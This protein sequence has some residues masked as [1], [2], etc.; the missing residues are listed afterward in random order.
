MTKRNSISIF[1]AI[2]TVL[3]GSTV[4]AS[5]ITEDLADCVEGVAV[6]Q[7]LKAKMSLK[8]AEFAAYHSDCIP[9]VSAVDPVLVGMTG[10]ILVLQSLSPAKLARDA[11]VCTDQIF[12]VAQRPIA[13]MIDTAMNQSGLSSILPSTS[14]TL[15]R[16]IANGASNEALYSIPGMTV[17]TSKLTCGCAVAE[18]GVPVEALKETVENGLKTINSCTGVVTK[19]I[20]GAYAAAYAGV[21]AVL[22]AATKIYNTAQNALNS[23]GCGWLWSC[24]SA[25]SGPPFFC[26]GYGLVRAQGSSVDN[27]RAQYDNLWKMVNGESQTSIFNSSNLSWTG[28]NTPKKEPPPSPY[29]AMIDTCETQYVNDV[30]RINKDLALTEAAAKAQAEGSNYALA[31][32]AR[33]WPECQNDPV[34]LNGIGGVSNLFY[35]DIQDPDIRAYFGKNSADPFH[36]TVKG[37]NEKYRPNAQIIVGAGRD[38]RYAVLRANA[39]AAPTD[40]LIAFGCNPFLGRARQSLCTSALG[41]NTCKQYVNAGA[42]NFCVSSTA[43]GAYFSAGRHL[44]DFVQSAGCV[45]LM[46]SAQRTNQQN[47]APMRPIT[48]VQASR[49]PALVR[50]ERTVSLTE[51]QNFQCLSPSA[52]RNCK[53]FQSGGSLVDCGPSRS[54]TLA[55]TRPIT[56]NTIASLEKLGGVQG[57]RGLGQIPPATSMVPALP[58]LRSRVPRLQPA[59]VTEAPPTTTTQALPPLILAPSRQLP[60]L[61][62]RPG[63]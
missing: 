30:D 63:S 2:L 44:R 55:A 39:A 11:D 24:P 23:L 54:L 7:L 53:S 26:T 49:S 20:G 35:G 22:D 33:W 13:G 52:W 19:L 12:S 50:L 56:L 57:V 6:D 4:S 31:Y 14:R 41:M 51:T 27:I 60:A 29:N 1:L 58:G 16:N 21:E 48:G 37:L 32:A 40:R 25:P 36:A 9:L 18:T 10:G 17:I 42:W 15:L 46:S 8:A 62:R 45:P 61:K 3:F 43:P 34:C 47:N 28:Q 5:T 59:P 38:R